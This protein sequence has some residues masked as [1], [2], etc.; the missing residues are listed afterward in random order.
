MILV[1]IMKA[2]FFRLKLICGSIQNVAVLLI[3]PPLIILLTAQ[4]MQEATHPQNVP[5]VLL[6]YDQ[7]RYSE[8]IIAGLHENPVLEIHTMENERQATRQVKTGAK[9]AAFIIKPGLQENI[10]SEDLGELVKVIYSP[11]SLVAET[12]NEIAAG[13]I[14]RLASKVS[15]ANMVIDYFQR[16]ELPIQGEQNDNGEQ[17]L[18]QQAWNYTAAQ[19]EP[20]PTVGLES[21]YWDAADHAASEQIYHPE[22]GNL[23]FIVSMIT[24]LIMYLSIFL[25]GD[26]VREKNS[27]IGVRIRTINTGSIIYNTGNALAVLLAVWIVSML[28]WIITMIFLPVNLSLSLPL[29]TLLSA[30]LITCLSLA[31]VIA[32][33]TRTTGQLQISGF[34]VTIIT[35]SLGIIVLQLGDIAEH[36]EALAMITPQSWVITGIRD[37]VYYQH[38]W[39]TIIP[40]LAALLTMA[41]IFWG[42]SQKVGKIND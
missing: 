14:I 36:I 38:N 24:I 35:S 19:W 40:S 41:I 12:L 5:V 26:M 10:L 32:N 6:D 39:E 18:W 29:I 7:S 3:L 28:T 15:A 20:S 34:L 21:S 42:L 22:E 25:Q 33:L 30:Y 2:A 17:E 16:F 37:L 11:R 27:S 31:Y 9:E 8:N 13:E 4:V 23:L 1:Q